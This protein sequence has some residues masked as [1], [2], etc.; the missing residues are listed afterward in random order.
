[1]TSVD[2]FDMSSDRTHFRLYPIVRGTDPTF[3]IKC[4]VEDELKRRQGTVKRRSR[5][6]T[7]IRLPFLPSS[8]RSRL[9]CLAAVERVPLRIANRSFGRS[10]TFD[11]SS[12]DSDSRASIRRTTCVVHIPRPILRARPSRLDVDVRPRGV[13]NDD[14]VRR[15]EQQWQQKKKETFLAC[16]VCDKC[17]RVSTD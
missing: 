8:P 4:F 15:P 6:S 3:L 5:L 13:E 14:D 17:D 7:T 12:I 16:D 10:S 9:E 1:M 11:S 2:R